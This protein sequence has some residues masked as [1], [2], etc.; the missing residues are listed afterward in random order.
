[1]SIFLNEIMFLK[2]SR[3]NKMT[4]MEFEKK[5]QNYEKLSTKKKLNLKILFNLKVH[6][7]WFP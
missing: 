5:D 7:L 4:L 3:L 1:M 2:K 6:H